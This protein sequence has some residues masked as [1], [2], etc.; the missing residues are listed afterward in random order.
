MKTLKTI[1]Q[2]IYVNFK[3]IFTYLGAAFGGGVIGV[4]IMSLI[5]ATTDKP[6][7]YSTIGTAF[8]LGLTL[9]VFFFAQSL[10][11]QADFYVTVSMNRARVPYFFGRYILLV[12][13]LLAAVGAAYIVNVLEMNVIG[14]MLS[15][16]GEVE[17]L[18]NGVEPGLFTALILSVPLLI[19]LFTAL[20][21]LFERKFFWVLWGLYM[22]GALGGPRI[23]IA[24]KKNP[25][26]I[27]AQIGESV[28]RL[29]NM[30]TTAWLIIGAVTVAILLVADILIYK[31][32]AVKL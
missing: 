10:G 31:K 3:E 23:S 16:N 22:I 30:G 14:P 20:Y 27:P 2:F 7:E 28:M 13:D 12:I 17:Q 21:V 19:I 6:I 26:S 11:G 9:I 4:I 5:L 8:A 29:I 1:G 18:I 15:T 25:G 32:M 24:M